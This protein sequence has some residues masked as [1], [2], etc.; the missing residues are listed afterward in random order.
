M[1]EICDRSP[2][3]G[4]LG[5]LGSYIFG[6]KKGFIMSCTDE[7]REIHKVNI[8]YCPFCGTRLEI[9]GMEDRY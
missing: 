5:A 2:C 8:K 3:D 9:M 1:P 6:S 4:L 7:A